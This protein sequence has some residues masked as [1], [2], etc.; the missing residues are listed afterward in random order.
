MEY[1]FEYNYRL[2]VRWPRIQ[3]SFHNHFF[4]DQRSIKSYVTKPDIITY[5]IPYHWLFAYFDISIHSYFTV[6]QTTFTSA[7]NDSGK[8]VL[9]LL[10]RIDNDQYSPYLY[11]LYIYSVNLCFKYEA[12]CIFL[13]HSNKLFEL[14]D[15]I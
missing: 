13:S 14:T 2:T 7:L 5:A 15:Q 3:F 6:V 4:S 12:Q 1:N 10:N 8:I 9:V 11:I